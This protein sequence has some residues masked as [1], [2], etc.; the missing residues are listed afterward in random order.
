MQLLNYR[1]LLK[2]LVPCSILGVTLASYGCQ[3]TE[4]SQPTTPDPAASVEADEQAVIE[5]HQALID[6]YQS[7]DIDAFTRHLAPA[8]NLLIFHP[9]LQS[10]YDG[11]ED[12][13]EGLGKMFE[14]FSQTTWTDFHPI[15][16]IEGDIGWL[17]SQVLVESPELE[18]PF[19]GRGTEIWLRRDDGW[20]L[21]HGHWS[22]TPE[23]PSGISQD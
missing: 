17:T 11:I 13:R 12:V 23:E 2:H 19:A 22:E 20:K 4:Q 16:S 14:R 3:S 1:S 8:P 5:A 7:V 15:V 10:R 18:V 21:V 9:R 6:A